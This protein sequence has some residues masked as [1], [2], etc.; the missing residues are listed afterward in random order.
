MSGDV[1]KTHLDRLYH[2]YNSRQWVH[3]DTLEY[4]YD[5]PDL[6]D[7]ETVGIIASSLAYK[8]VAQILNS[9]GDKNFLF[10]T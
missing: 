5:Y 8:R 10:R 7:R 4:L 3:P 1:V 9:V 6:R 2:H